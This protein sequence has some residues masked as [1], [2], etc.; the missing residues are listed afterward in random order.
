[1]QN[2]LF[3]L[4]QACICVC[5]ELNYKEKTYFC[6]DPKSKFLSFPF[7]TTEEAKPSM[8]TTLPSLS[9]LKSPIP[10]C[11]HTSSHSSRV[12]ETLEFG[13]VR[14]P[15]SN[16]S[17][18]LTV[19]PKQPGSPSWHR[20]GKFDQQAF[21]LLLLK[22]KHNQPCGQEVSGF[23]T[24]NWE[25]GV[26]LESWGLGY[27]LQPHVSCSHPPKTNSSPWGMV[28]MTYICNLF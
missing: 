3:L 18:T 27:P 5:Y 6:G 23:S 20:Q 28:K 13:G 8:W 10:C 9:C 1:M 22:N 25:V 4:S 2:I 17:I 26:T 11:A 14:A 12:A 7:P 16:T 21:Q 19:T 24:L 15:P